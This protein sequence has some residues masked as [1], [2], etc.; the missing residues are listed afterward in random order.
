LKLGIDLWIL[1]AN[2]KMMKK[3][4]KGKL[5]KTKKIEI[6]IIFKRNNEI[7]CSNF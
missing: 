2:Q 3:N 1:F 6:I 7:K 5:S 4:S